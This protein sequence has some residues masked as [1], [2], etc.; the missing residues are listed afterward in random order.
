MLLIDMAQFQGYTQMSYKLEIPLERL[1]THA[2][3]KKRL[4]VK[5]IVFN[6]EQLRE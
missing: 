3:V 1:A 2:Y 5:L 6:R 4:K